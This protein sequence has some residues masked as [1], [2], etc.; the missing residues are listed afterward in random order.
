MIIFINGSINSGKSTVAKGLVNKLDKPVA[1]VEIDN[2]SAF[3]IGMSIDDKVLTNLE[4][5]VLMIRNLSSKGFN[6][7]VPYPLSEKNYAFITSRFNDLNQKIYTFT[8]SPKIDKVLQSTEARQLTDW[9]KERIKHHY[10][11]GILNPSFGTIIDN[12]DQTPEQTIEQ[13]YSLIM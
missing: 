11:I 10:E 1:L 7:V 9:E 6:I 3:L 13:I 2:L 4:N 8:L 5:A 12:T